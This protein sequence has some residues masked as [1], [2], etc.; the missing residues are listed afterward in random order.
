MTSLIQGSPEW[1]QF[2]R[3][4]VTAS[5]VGALLGQVS[6]ISRNKAYKSITNDSGF[7]DNPAMLWGREHEIDG[8]RE[9]E[10]RTHTAVVQTGAHTHEQHD[11]F[12]G[13]PDGL[14]GEYG[15]IEV[16]CPFYRR[17]VH[18]KI[19]GHYWMQMNACMEVANRGWCDFVSW[20]PDK[21]AIY[22][23]WRDKATFAKLFPY[24][25]QVHEAIVAGNET[26]PPLSIKQRAEITRIV[27]AASKQTVDYRSYLARRPCKLFSTS[28]KIDRVT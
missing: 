16:K 17:E 9:Y 25:E 19:P 14:V 15:M 1:L 4:K 28:K 27:E 8:I 23:V 21:V 13:S 2:R 24:Y 26:P 18:G 7:T 22:R 6:Y 5:N 10:R 20:T 12:L 3:G 11:W